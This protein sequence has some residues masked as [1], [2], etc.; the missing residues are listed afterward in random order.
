FCVADVSGKGIA[1]SLLMSNFQA[2]LRAM[3]RHSDRSLEQLVHGLNERV[4]SS[5]RG[6]RF[7]TLFI[8][9]IDLRTRYLDFV[10]AGHNA[11]LLIQQDTLEQLRDGSIALGMMPKL[12]FLKPGSVQI[13]KGS[14]ILCYTDG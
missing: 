12:P 7:I 6:E 1:A 11:P 14:R 2:T 10:N 4:H 5:A 13:G 3:A 9:R 8:G